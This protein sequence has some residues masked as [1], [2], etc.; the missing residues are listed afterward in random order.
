MHRFDSIYKQVSFKGEANYRFLR[1]AVLKIPDAA[2]SAMYRATFSYE[3][4][5][6][7]V[8]N[9]ENT[10]KSFTLPSTNTATK[11]ENRP[12]LPRFKN[13]KLLVSPNT[14]VQNMVSN[15]TLW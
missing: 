5:R 6:K 1:I 8:K 4:L 10:M 11:T 13:V 3:K 12:E 9:F 15:S 7:A 2:T 14:R